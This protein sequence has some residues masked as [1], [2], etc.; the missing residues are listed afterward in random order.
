[1]KIKQDEPNQRNYWAYIK[2]LQKVRYDKEK[3]LGNFNNSIQLEETK[4]QYE[5]TITSLKV[6]V[7]MQ[8]KNYNRKVND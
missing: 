7:A 8:K 3:E 5:W 4:G 1:M 2:W 6:I